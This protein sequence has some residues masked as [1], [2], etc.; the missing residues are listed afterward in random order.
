M[1]VLI[2]APVRGVVV[3]IDVMYMGLWILSAQTVQTKFDAATLHSNPEVARDTGMVDD[4]S[5]S[6]KVC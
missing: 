4:G 1:H 2:D 5:G 6:K 3:L